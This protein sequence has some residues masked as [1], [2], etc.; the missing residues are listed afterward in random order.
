MIGKTIGKYRIV[1]QLGR[2]GS[3]IVY[4]AVD[5]T[6]HRDVAIKALSPDLAN[7]EV[8]KRFR[9]EAT[10]L[11]KLNHPHI[12]TIYELVRADDDLLMVMEFVRGETLDR[13][14]Q[15]IGPIP[16]D[17]AAY[18]IDR[19]LSAL[20]HAHRAGVV[21]R[22]M[23][24]ANVMVTDGGGVKIMDFGIARV[25][26]AEQMTVDGRLMGTPAYMPP[27]Q[28]L[29]QDVDGRADLYSVGVLFYR[30]L[31]AALPFKAD[32]AIAMMQRQILEPPM[33]MHVH[34]ADLPDWC[35]PIVLRAL[36]KAPEERFQTAEE[37]RE[38][39]RR[40][41][42]VLVTADFAQS[43][44]IEVPAIDTL[45]VARHGVE[46]TVPDATARPAPSSRRALAWTNAAVAVV[47]IGGALGYIALQR[48]A[49]DAA[50]AAP[51]PSDHVLHEPTAPE[52][53]PPDPA[54]A[55]EPVR[56]A[57][58]KVVVPAAPASR[59][60]NEPVETP[61]P[62]ERVVHRGGAVPE[63]PLVF[64]TRTVVGT[65]KPREHEAQLVLADGRIT[66]TPELE[67][68]YPFYSI[69]Y[70]SVISITYSRG[71]DPLWNS[72][73]GPVPVTRGGGTLG[74][75]GIMVSRDWISLR[76]NT[77]DQFVTMR[78]DDVL[79]RRVLLALEERTGRK[80]ELIAEPKEP[81]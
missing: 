12:A 2:G 39:L 6:L 73:E 5:E 54:P 58:A 38:E 67:A 19:I 31:T 30:L 10:I 76:T 20:E 8:M 25:R 29:G 27:E 34:G 37:F 26:G 4:L 24:P 33:P 50:I 63:A 48:Q 41:T 35:E 7:A 77:Q 15:R 74:R 44:P 3:G 21:H 59:R 49:A 72:P 68:E 43:F 75:L 60:V 52:P 51:A 11:A 55:V 70:A 17:R 80:P 53:A 23:K 42:G 28:V 32:T 81:R 56:H 22:D 16:P 13:L 65:K 71:R 66:V 9:A 78:F 62:T 40:A 14:S 36:A 64:E 45:D 61:A 47:A 18:L 79:V 57:A 69:P 46:M 1:G